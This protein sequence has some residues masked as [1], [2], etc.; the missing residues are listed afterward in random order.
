MERAAYRDR[1][2]GERSINLRKQIRAA[3]TGYGTRAAV[4]DGTVHV[5]SIRIRLRDLTRSK[6]TA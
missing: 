5:P 4:D 2:T 3:A 1:T 6:N